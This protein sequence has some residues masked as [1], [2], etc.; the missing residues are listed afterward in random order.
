MCIRDRPGTL[1]Q[2]HNSLKK[3]AMFI[4]AFII[5]IAEF[6]FNVM[7]VARSSSDLLLHPL[8]S[9]ADNVFRWIIVDLGGLIWSETSIAETFP[10]GIIILELSYLKLAL[11]GL[12]IIIAL[13]FSPKGLLPE[14]PFR[15]RRPKIGSK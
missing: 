2:I 9:Y 10:K 5:V 8:T 14:I 1:K 15:Q 4:G 7:V 12:V 13:R 11:I 6:I 3:E